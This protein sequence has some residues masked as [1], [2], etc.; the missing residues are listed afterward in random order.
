MKELAVGGG[1][2]KAL[3]MTKGLYMFGMQ[4]LP[5]YT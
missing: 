4:G 1:T 2:G 5:T 3:K